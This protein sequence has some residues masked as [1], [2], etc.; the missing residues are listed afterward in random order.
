MKKTMKVLALVLALGATV[1]TL[2]AY[3]IETGFFSADE[4]EHKITQLMELRKEIDVK[5]E[6]FDPKISS[7]NAEFPE[8]TSKEELNEAIAR[9]ALRYLQAIGAEDALIRVIQKPEFQSL[10]EHGEPGI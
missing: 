7:V 1:Q 9:H 2:R 8:V 5:G 10:R 4:E 6:S 3:A